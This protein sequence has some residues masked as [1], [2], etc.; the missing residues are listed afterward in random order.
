MGISEDHRLK[1][2]RRAQRKGPP[3]LKETLAWSTRCF[4]P[5]LSFYLDVCPWSRSSASAC[6]E[7]TCSRGMLP[8]TPPR[9]PSHTCS[10]R[11]DSAGFQQPPARTHRALPEGLPLPPRAGSHPRHGISSANIWVNTSPWSSGGQ[12]GCEHCWGQHRLPEQSYCP[13]H[14]CATPPYAASHGAKPSHWEVLL[15][16]QVLAAPLVR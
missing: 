15:P 10:T 2:R 7:P 8:F 6:E 16:S 9:A 5:Q 1:A 11:G 12:G 4:Q 13:G 14:A 3:A